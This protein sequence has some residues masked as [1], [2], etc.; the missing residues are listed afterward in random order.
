M[1]VDNLRIK[2]YT[3]KKILPNL[4]MAAWLLLKVKISLGYAEDVIVY[5]SVDLRGM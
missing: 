5:S 3:F 4:E 1:F 2:I